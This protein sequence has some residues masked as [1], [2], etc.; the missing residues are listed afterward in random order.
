MQQEEGSSN[1][2][3]VISPLHEE[4]TERQNFDVISQQV[5]ESVEIPRIIIPQRQHSIPSIMLSNIER[6]AF[7]NNIESSSP[8]LSLSLIV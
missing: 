7:N 1:N 5:V 2:D 8:I 3:M 6:N 4:H